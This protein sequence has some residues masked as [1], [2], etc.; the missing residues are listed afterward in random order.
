MVGSIATLPGPLVR[1]KKWD[2]FRGFL[3]FSRQTKRAVTLEASGHVTSTESS[4]GDGGSAP[5]L[6]RG[7]GAGALP[8]SSWCCR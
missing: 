8:P 5:G 7:S 2:I 1:D 6:G 4:D 3:G